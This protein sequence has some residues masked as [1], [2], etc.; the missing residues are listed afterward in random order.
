MMTLLVLF[1]PIAISH[2]FYKSHTVEHAHS[3]TSPSVTHTP[4]HASPRCRDGNPLLPQPPCLPSWMSPPPEVPS[5]CGHHPAAHFPIA[6]SYLSS[7]FMYQTQIV[8]IFFVSL[9]SVKVMSV[10]FFNCT[11]FMWFLFSYLNPSFNPTSR[12]LP[13][14]HLLLTSTP[15]SRTKLPWWF[16]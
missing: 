3:V 15:S 11:F 16:A 1:S 14:L 13:H 6:L 10:T 2:G 9:P 12:C 8:Y 4:A 5:Q 7:N